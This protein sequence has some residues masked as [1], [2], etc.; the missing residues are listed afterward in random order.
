MSAEVVVPWSKLLQQPNQVVSLLEEAVSVRLARRD[1]EDL[2]ITRASRAERQAGSIGDITRTMAAMVRAEGGADVI[3]RAVPDA[4]PWI[5]VMPAEALDEFAE[6]FVETA[7][8]C[9]ELG[10]FAPLEVV[11]ASWKHT[12]EI[13]ADPE[14]HAIL[15]RPLTLDGPRVPMPEVRE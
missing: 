11:V 7:R 12:A 4:F 13:E 3:R 6:E 10:V 14:L 2:V 9:A 8:G 1:A 15:T 5:R